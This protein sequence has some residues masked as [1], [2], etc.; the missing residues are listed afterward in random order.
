MNF[1]RP[2]TLEEYADFVEGLASPATMKSKETM[3]N[4]TA[5][6]ICGEAGEVSEVVKKHLFH[7][8]DFDREKFLSELSDCL[9]YLTLGTKAIDASLQDVINKNVEKLRARY[10]GGVFSKEEFLAKEKAKGE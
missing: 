3:L 5:L 6:G 8:K 1:D 4:T 7:G 9:W 2:L 10:K